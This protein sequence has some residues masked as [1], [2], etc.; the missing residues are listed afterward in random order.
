M[1]I[2][3]LYAI[4]LLACHLTIKKIKVDKAKYMTEA[5]AAMNKVVTEWYT[6]GIPASK[7]RKRSILPK[8]LAL[9]YIRVTENLIMA[10]NER[11]F[12]KNEFHC[13]FGTDIVHNFRNDTILSSLA[14]TDQLIQDYI[15][16]Y[17]KQIS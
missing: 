4:A 17:N 10:Y 5:T 9:N 11:V 8:I 2:I 12:D 16:E 15:K 14:E 7:S 3:V 13:L 1:S 6:E